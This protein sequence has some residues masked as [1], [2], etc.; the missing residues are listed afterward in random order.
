MK[1]SHNGPETSVIPA[2]ESVLVPAALLPQIVQE[3]QRIDT[4]LRAEGSLCNYDPTTP[5]GTILDLVL[6]AAEGCSAAE[7]DGWQG[8]IRYWRIGAAVG[9]DPGSGEIAAVPSLVLYESERRI[10]RLFGMPV[11]GAWYQLM[12]HLQSR[13]TAPTIPVIVRR[14]PSQTAGRS[15]W[16]VQLDATRIRRETP[17]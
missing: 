6:C 16:T 17:P 11:I 5:D 2:A 10:V 7:K 13:W 12:G 9:C 14:K 1:K 8:E 4:A 15:Y 3:M